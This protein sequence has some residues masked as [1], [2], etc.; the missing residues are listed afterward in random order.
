MSRDPV[1]RN[2]LSPQAGYPQGRFRGSFDPAMGRGYRAGDRVVIAAGEQ[3]TLVNHGLVDQYFRWKISL[4]ADSAEGAVYDPNTAYPIIVTVTGKNENDAIPRQ[5]IVGLGRGQVL[6]V[7]GRSLQVLALNPT[8][9]PIGMHYSLDEATP[10]L[11]SWTTD[12]AVTVG[13]G[14]EYPLDVAAF[15]Q[16]LQLVGLTGATTWTLRGYDAAGT[17]VSNEVLSPPRSA[18][19]PL[20]P[21]L[22]Y[23]LEPTA[24]VGTHS[25][26]IVYSCVG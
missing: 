24:G 17:L 10:G 23:T 13:T 1:G 5:T 4:F 2:V 9:Q 19:I 26:L 14:V 25:C 20:A 7:P 12:E 18:I 21:S 16:A 6:Y 3:V 11:S 15:A 22:Y 8:E